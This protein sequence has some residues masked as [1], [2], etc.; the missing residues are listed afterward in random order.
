MVAIVAAMCGEIEGD[1]KA[2]LAGSEIAAVEGVRILRGREARILADGPGLLDVHGRVGP[3]QEGRQAGIGVE[4]IEALGIARAIGG[5]QRDPLGRFG[6][7]ARRI[8][9]QAMAPAT[10]PSKNPALVCHLVPFS[11][12]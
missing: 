10:R 7:R 8:P 5:L 3:A 4:E 2:L 12:I 11:S 6:H 9:P 1:R